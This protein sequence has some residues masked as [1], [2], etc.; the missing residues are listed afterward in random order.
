MRFIIGSIKLNR[1]YRVLNNTSGYNFITLEKIVTTGETNG[2]GNWSR[3]TRVYPT[4]NEVTL[5]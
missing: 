1:I 3:K 5:Q 4:V 2:N